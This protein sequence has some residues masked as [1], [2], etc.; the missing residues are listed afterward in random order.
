MEREEDM[1][2]FIFSTELNI[3]MPCI[4]ACSF[5]KIEQSDLV[6]TS[7][8]ILMLDLVRNYKRKEFSDVNNPNIYLEKGDCCTTYKLS[9]LYDVS[10]IYKGYKILLCYYNHDFSTAYTF[11]IT[12]QEVSEWLIADMIL[13]S[14]R[15]FWGSRKSG[16]NILHY[17]QF[18]NELKYEWVCAMKRG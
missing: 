16:N 15:L 10:I 1:S 11:S 13:S 8:E 12:V 14:M 7:A 17:A 5:K 6:F 18:S 3:K 2:Y 9:S 4:E